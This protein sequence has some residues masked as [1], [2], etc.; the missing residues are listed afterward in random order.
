MMDAFPYLL[1]YYLE[2]YVYNDDIYRSP[3][4]L[5]RR[6]RRARR[7]LRKVMSKGG[8]GQTKTKVKSVPSAIYLIS[9]AASVAGQHKDDREQHGRKDT[10]N[11]VKNMGS[12]K[13]R[14]RHDIDDNQAPVTE[15]I[16]DEIADASST[17]YSSSMESLAESWDDHEIT[18][19]YEEE[20]KAKSHS[21]CIQMIKD[22]EE[23]MEARRKKHDEKM[24][25]LMVQME[26]AVSK[27]R[28]I[29]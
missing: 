9:K 29:K 12:V 6:D 2:E 28:N 10:K 21:Q 14:S 4:E 3:R 17:V 5:E 16:A 24:K 13:A 1:L 11:E 27:L 20:Q 26:E 7:K 25:A 19:K 23:K 22:N 8:R 15:K 18:V